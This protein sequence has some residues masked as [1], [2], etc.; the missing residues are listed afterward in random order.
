MDKRALCIGI[1]DYPGTGSDLAGCVNDANDWAE[2]LAGRGF[3]VS[4]ML[5]AAATREAMLEGM[6]KLVSAADSGDVVVI[7]YSGHGGQ[8]LLSA[9][10]STLQRIVMSLPSKLYGPA[11]T[12]R[13]NAR[14][15]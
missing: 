7:S 11:G 1:N 6:R 10:T 4:V 2:A 3:E 5:D 12:F 15:S 9:T 8:V 14:R 13:R